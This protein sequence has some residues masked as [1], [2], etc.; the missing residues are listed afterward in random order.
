MRAL[1]ARPDALDS[2]LGEIYDSIEAAAQHLQ[3]TAVHRHVDEGLSALEVMVS[4]VGSFAQGTTS[5]DLPG[6]FAIAAY[7]GADNPA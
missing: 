3:Y 7:P 6:F 5:S 2:F 4:F 1:T